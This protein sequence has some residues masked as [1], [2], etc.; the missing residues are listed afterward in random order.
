M[1]EIDGV[2]ED[3]SSSHVYVFFTPFVRT[4]FDINQDKKQKKT[5]SQFVCLFDCREEWLLALSKQ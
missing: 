1:T 3:V 4:F 5:L 2:S